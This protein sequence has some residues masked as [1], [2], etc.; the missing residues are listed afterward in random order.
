MGMCVV[1]YLCFTDGWGEYVRSRNCMCVYVFVFVC[2]YFVS[3]FS[4][5]EIF[6]L[7][8]SFFSLLSLGVKR[9][10]KVLDRTFAAETHR[11]G[12]L[13]VNERFVCVCVCV[14]LCG[15]FFVYVDVCMCVYVLVG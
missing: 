6:S 11:V 10:I 4:H 8:S 13:F 2:V 7:L 1:V 3:L 5:L 9:A 12:V 14:C 15:Y